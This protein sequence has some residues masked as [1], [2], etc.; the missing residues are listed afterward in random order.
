MRVIPGAPPTEGAE[1]E[2]GRQG[3]RRAVSWIS[4]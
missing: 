1:N 4:P 3:Q 2:A